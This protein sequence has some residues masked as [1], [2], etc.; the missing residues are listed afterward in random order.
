[1]MDRRLLE[2][3]DIVLPLGGR[4]DGWGLRGAAFR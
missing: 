3:L 2:I 1:M 4:Y